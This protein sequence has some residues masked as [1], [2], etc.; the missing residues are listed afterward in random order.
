M[1][2]YP[3]VL[4]FL[5]LLGA[6]SFPVPAASSEENGWASPSIYSPVAFISTASLCRLGRKIGHDILEFL[7]VLLVAD[8]RENVQYRIERFPAENPC[9]SN[10]QELRD[11]KQA[12]DEAVDAVSRVQ[13]TCQQSRF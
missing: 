13:I 3:F 4:Q 1:N 11:P 5:F 7:L 2:I 8:D 12:S 9:A 6:F 10:G